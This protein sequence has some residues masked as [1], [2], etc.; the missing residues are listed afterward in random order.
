VIEI[1]PNHLQA[2][3][4]LISVYERMKNWQ[5]ALDEIETVRRIAGKTQNQQAINLA[6]KS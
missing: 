5:K 1:N 6:E 2:H 3:L 4:N